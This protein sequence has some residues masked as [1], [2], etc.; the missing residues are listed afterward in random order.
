[1]TAVEAPWQH[2][3]VERHGGVLGEIIH[4]TTTETKARGLEDMTRVV[5]FAAMA[6]NRRPGRSGDV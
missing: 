1:M 5:T 3:M 4:V 2:G 6:K